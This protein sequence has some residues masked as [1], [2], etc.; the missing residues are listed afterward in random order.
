MTF[1]TT[2]LHEVLYLETSSK[3]CL[4]NLIVSINQT[5]QFA[6]AS[7]TLHC[8]RPYCR[9]LSELFLY[10]VCAYTGAFFIPYLIFLF[11]CGIPVFFLETS[12]GQYTS[13]G[14]ITCWRKICPL[15]EGNPYFLQR[16]NSICV[17]D[18]KNQTKSGYFTLVL[19]SLCLCVEEHQSS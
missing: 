12:L 8:L 17:N 18:V 11:A 9:Y 14:G 2:T 6:P 3:K 4:C 15:F 19:H 5:Q 1:I 13:E 7:I 16:H 10:S